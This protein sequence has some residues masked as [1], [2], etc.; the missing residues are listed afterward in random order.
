MELT[1]HKL[2]EGFLITS[3]EETKNDEWFY[4]PFIK[5]VQINCN[6][7]DCL[8]VIAQ[9]DQIDFSDLSEKEQKE[10]G[11]FDV[12]KLALKEFM[13]PEKLFHSMKNSSQNEYLLEEEYGKENTVV[14]FQCIAFIKSF[15]KLQEI[16]SDRKFT[17]EDMGKCY[18]EG[19]Y[20]GSLKDSPVKDFSL[21]SESLSQPKSWKIDGLWEN[22]K[23]KITKIWN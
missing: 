19:F 23:F 8:K 11:Y 13:F 10:I 7:N 4:N 12:E 15:Q 3:D 22:N 6:S 1:L 16:F 20:Q 5:E 2:S 14:Y 21:Y 18:E 9:Q 17:L